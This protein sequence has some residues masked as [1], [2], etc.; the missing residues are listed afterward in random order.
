MDLL[1]KIWGEVIKIESR[2]EFQA[3][4]LYYF[5][6]NSLCICS[7][8]HK[9]STALDCL[10]RERSAQTAAANFAVVLFYTLNPFMFSVVILNTRVLPQEMALMNVELSAEWKIESVARTYFNS[11]GRISNIKAVLLFVN[12]NIT[13]YSREHVVR[14]KAHA[15]TSAHGSQ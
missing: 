14:D 1:T 12:Y 10:H 2:V 6:E 11:D 4:S 13:G 7:I 8:S 15:D 5:S 3:I 9:W